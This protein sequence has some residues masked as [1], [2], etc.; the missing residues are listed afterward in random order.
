[1]CCVSSRGQ[2]EI[3]DS[4]KPLIPLYGCQ[5]GTDNHKRG[6][7]ALVDLI[8]G[9]VGS[10]SSQG[11]VS[12]E[13]GCSGRSSDQLPGIGHARGNDG[14]DSTISSLIC[15]LCL[16]SPPMVSL[17]HGSTAHQATCLPCAR[18]L[19]RRK[20]PC[21]ICRQKIEKIITNYVVGATA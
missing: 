8:N 12:G 15:C 13:G 19:V 1:M 9:G 20:A 11:E 10:L 6:G 7:A 2:C 4:V 17:L 14:G 16:S 3:C 18:A 21:P 5:S